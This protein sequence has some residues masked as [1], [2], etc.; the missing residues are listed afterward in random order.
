MRAG[1]DRLDGGTG[2]PVVS[3]RSESGQ[4]ILSVKEGSGMWLWSDVEVVVLSSHMSVTSCSLTGRRDNVQCLT[5]TAI[6]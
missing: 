5:I 3:Q 4:A 6:F 2:T 1:T